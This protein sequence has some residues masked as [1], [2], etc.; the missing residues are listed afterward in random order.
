MERNIIASNSATYNETEG[1]AA[2][3]ALLC[4]STKVT[5]KL[6]RCSCIWNTEIHPLARF[7][8]CRNPDVSGPDWKDSQEQKKGEQ[9]KAKA[10]FSLTELVVVVAIMMVVSGLSLP[11]ISRI[12]DNAKLNAAAQQVAS[13]YQQGKIRAT[14]DNNYYLLPMVA[15]GAQGSRI[16]LDL[17]GDGACSATEPQAQISGAV[18]LS[19]AVVPLQLDPTALG[20]TDL[21]NSENAVNYTQQGIMERALA[22]NALGL[23][24]IRQSSTSPC[25]GP[26]GWVQYLQLRSGDDVLF[27]AVTVSPTGT[28]KIWHYEPGNGAGGWF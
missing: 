17:N 1:A 14:Q 12:L 10:G 3:C 25:S 24:C 11:S 9:V 2:A 7:P 19:N 6:E 8:G 26:L 13:I 20:V 28:V 4:L 22:W 23:P 5:Q 15:N 27:A 21:S 18:D 16:C